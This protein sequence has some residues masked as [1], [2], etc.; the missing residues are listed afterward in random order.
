VPNLGAY[1]VVLGD[2]DQDGDLDVVRG[3]GPVIFLDVNRGDGT[4]DP[5]SPEHFF[6]VEGFHALQVGALSLVDTDQDGDLDLWIGQGGL[7]EIYWGAHTQLHSATYAR[8]GTTSSLY[9]FGF[10]GV[11]ILAAS[12]ARRST[13]L[14][15]PFGRFW[16]DP[17]TM[18]V[19]PAPIPVARN[20][21]GQRLLPIPNSLALRNRTLQFQALHLS[22][23][24]AWNRL[25]NVTAI[26]FY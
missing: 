10:E 14:A 7:T 15:T 9:A 13:P 23:S 21:I 20:G 24:R 25:T 4:F 8:V 5:K 19:D 6:G 22:P 16:L 12:A 2:L 17:A 26:T 1:A 3:A 11:A 18:V